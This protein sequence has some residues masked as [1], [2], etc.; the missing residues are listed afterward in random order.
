MP[1]PGGDDG[2]AVKA[3]PTKP[4]EG[5]KTGTSGLRKKTKEFMQPNYLANWV[6]S[7]FNAL[8]AEVKDQTLALGG[9]GRYFGKEAA[10]IIIKLAAGNGFKKVVVGKDAILATPAAS[11]LIRQRKLYGELLA[12]P[13]PGSAVFD[14]VTASNIV[15]PAKLGPAGAWGASSCTGMV[16]PISRIADTCMLAPS[17]QVA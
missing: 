17:A 13:L 4:Y 9:D 3:T 10:Q 14:N 2:Q 15:L 12:V 6:Q 8:G 5:Q 1:S 7:L 16:A 11:A